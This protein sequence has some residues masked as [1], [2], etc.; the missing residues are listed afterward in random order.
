VND[1]LFLANLKPENF[2]AV[3]EIDDSLRT[4]WAVAALADFGF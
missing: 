3:V 2:V 4:L 1:V